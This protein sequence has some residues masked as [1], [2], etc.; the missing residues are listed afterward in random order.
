MDK[1]YNR[2]K[3]CAERNKKF[4]QEERVILEGNIFQNV[5]SL[6]KE[7]PQ[8]TF[9]LF[10][11]P[12]SIYYWDSLNQEGNLNRQLKIEEETIRMLLEYDNILLFSFNDQFDMIC[13]LNNYKDTVHY[14]EKINSKMLEWMYE[15]KHLLTKDNYIEYCNKVRNFYTSF[16]YNSLFVI[17]ESKH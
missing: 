8:I 17:S 11:T 13:D 9:Y 4:T 5:T 2:P 12:Y 15:R 16:E 10:F 14:G 7:N 1:V 3:W 6:A